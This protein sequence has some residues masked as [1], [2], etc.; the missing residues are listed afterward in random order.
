MTTAK[1][2]VLIIDDHQVVRDG[3]RAVL[4]KSSYEVVGEAASKNE[5][6]AQIAH[7]SPDVVIVD[8]NLPDGSGLEIISWARS[9]SKSIGLVVLTLNGDDQYLLAA[10][11]AGASAYVLKSAPVSEVL[12]AVAHSHA[13]PTTF[14]SHGLNTALAREKD[15]HGLT[16]RELQI[17]VLLPSGNTSANIAEVLFISEATVKT[18]LSNIYRKLAVSNRTEAVAIAMRDGLLD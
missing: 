3:L 8:L 6:L 4:T 7:K 1:I 17:L 14:A 5:G 18:H 15:G 2:R 16:A 13:A 9:I 12:A 10:L 11:R